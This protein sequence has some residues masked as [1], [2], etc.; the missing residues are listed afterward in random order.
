MNLDMFVTWIVVGLLTGGLISFVM[1]DGGHGRIWA[2]SRKRIAVR[3]RLP[4]SPGRPC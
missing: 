3:S 4:R 2:L 1:K